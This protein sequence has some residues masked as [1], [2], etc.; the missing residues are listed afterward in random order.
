MTNDQH[1]CFISD[2]LYHYLNQSEGVSAGG[3]QR[4]QYLLAQELLDRDYRVSAIVGDY[5]QPIEETNDG[6]RTIR[7]C[8]KRVSSISDSVTALRELYK[9]IKRADADTYYVRGAP[10]LFIA[11]RITTAL[12]RKPLVFCLANDSDIQDEYL[13]SRY[14]K[15]FTLLYSNTVPTADA[16]V[17]QTKRQQELTEET[18]NVRPS[19]IPNAYSMPPDTEVLSHE[20]RDYVLWVGSSDK[21]QKKPMRYVRLARQL[22]D[23]DF[24]MISQNIGDREHHE[25]I[26]SESRE[27]DNIQFFENVMPDKIHQYYR[28]ATALVNTSDYEGFPNTFLEAWRYATPVISL[29]YSLDGLLKQ[30]NIG[31]HSGSMDQLTDDVS[32]VHMDDQLRKTLGIAGR[33]FMEENYTLDAATDMYDDVFN[34]VIENRS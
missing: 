30:R 16:V 21:H 1:V 26:K 9:A 2:K 20:E 22:P 24:V 25:A 34:P 27:T 17:A 33:D 19:V 10:R 32:T 23:I 28:K 8:P 15:V 12:Q 6:I 29:R 5:G 14:G 3:A 31:R 13:R 18:F 7:G 11:T 4:Q